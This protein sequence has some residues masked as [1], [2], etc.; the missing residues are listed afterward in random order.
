MYKIVLVCALF[1]VVYSEDLCKICNNVPD[2]PVCGSD[3]ITYASLC[4]LVQIEC[5]EAR[6]IGMQ[7]NGTCPC[8]NKQQSHDFLTE[9]DKLTKLH[10][11]DLQNYSEDIMMVDVLE[12]N[13]G[14]ILNGEDKMVDL[15][16]CPLKQMAELPRRLIDWFHVLK[17]NELEKESRSKNGKVCKSIHL[18]T[19]A[20]LW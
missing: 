9:D 1:L 2:S 11:E 5:Q 6:E 15:N 10:K 13:E 16:G 18:G 12:K 4:K 19:V 8:S 7:C 20:K 17:T 3:G 14:I